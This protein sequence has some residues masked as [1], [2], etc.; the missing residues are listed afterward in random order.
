PK[1]EVVYKVTD[2]YSDADDRGIAWRD[3]DIAIKWPV[4]MLMAVLSGK[5]RGHPR[6][7][8]S[9]IYFP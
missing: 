2:F 6:L 8:D 3:P 5:D 4:D 7:A 9:P 1:T